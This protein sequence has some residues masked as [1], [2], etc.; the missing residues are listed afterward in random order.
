MSQLLATMATVDGIATYFGELPDTATYPAIRY[1]PVGGE[2]APALRG[3]GSLR[4]MVVQV[5]VFAIKLS[6]AWLLAEHARN[7]LTAAPLYGTLRI[8]PFSLPE[9]GVDAQRVSF[10]VSVWGSAT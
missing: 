4:N 5:D 10:Q 2:I 8:A 3:E 7:L 9:D 1:V 6:D